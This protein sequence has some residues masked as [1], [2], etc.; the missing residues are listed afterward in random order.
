[1]KDMKRIIMTFMVVALIALP[2]MAQQEW[3]STSSMQTSGSAYSSQVT[4]VGATAAP[5]E[6]TTTGASYA[7]GRPG[8]IRRYTY[9]DDWGTNQD[10]GE[11]NEGSP[12]GEPWVLAIFAAVFAGVIAL[13][14]R[15]AEKA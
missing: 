1:M 7:P 3:Q 2:T 8:S 12:I 4:S 9:D 10:W 13:R 14:K 11:G 6:A 5:S 15:Q